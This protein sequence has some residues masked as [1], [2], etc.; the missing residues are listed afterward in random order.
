L[1]GPAVD[2]GRLDANCSQVIAMLH[3]GFWSLTKQRLLRGQIFFF[4]T[5]AYLIVFVDKLRRKKFLHA[6]G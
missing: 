3:S 4:A 6:L 2:F 5:V 1:K